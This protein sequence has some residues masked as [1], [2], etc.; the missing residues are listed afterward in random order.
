MKCLDLFRGKL[1]VNY[2]SNI[3]RQF[4]DFVAFEYIIISIVF[5]VEAIFKINQYLKIIAS[6]FDII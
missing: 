1:L 3:I 6:V 5:V 4:K 2:E